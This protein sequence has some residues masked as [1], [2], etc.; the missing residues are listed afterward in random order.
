MALP[1][2]ITTTDKQHFNSKIE[3][4]NGAKQDASPSEVMLYEILQEL[5][6][7]PK[8]NKSGIPSGMLDKKDVMKVMR[9]LLGYDKGFPARKEGE[10]AYYWRTELREKIRKELGIVIK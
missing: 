5:K 6:K 10:G 4:L 2:K 9:W 3:Y 8:N 7:K 1:F